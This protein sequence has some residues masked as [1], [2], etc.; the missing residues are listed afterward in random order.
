MGFRIRQIEAERQFCE[1]VSVETI[2]QY[3]PLASIEQVVETRTKWGQSVGDYQ[4]KKQAYLR[5][6]FFGC[7]GNR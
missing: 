2:T 6:I 7:W 4:P 5:P 1:R 3:V